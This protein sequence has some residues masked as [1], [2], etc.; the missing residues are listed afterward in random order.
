MWYFFRGLHPFP[1]SLPNPMPLGDPTSRVNTGLILLHKFSFSHLQIHDMNTL[2]AAKET[3]MLLNEY[4][5]FVGM[6]SSRW[7]YPEQ[8]SCN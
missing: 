6:V 7:I 1:S 4:E 2:P 5:I 8:G 3:Q